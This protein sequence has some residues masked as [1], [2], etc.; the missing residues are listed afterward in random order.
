MRADG[1][2]T[3]IAEGATYK[4]FETVLAAKCIS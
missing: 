3:V 1:G 2:L 4:D